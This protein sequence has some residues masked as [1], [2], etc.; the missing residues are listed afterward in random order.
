MRMQRVEIDVPVFEGYDFLRLGTVHECEAN[1]SNIKVCRV[2]QNDDGTYC[3]GLLNTSRFYNEETCL[4]YRKKQP[5]K[6]IY[7]EAREDYLKRGDLY[8]NDNG[9]VNEWIFKDQSRDK[10]I[11]LAKV[12]DDFEVKNGWRIQKND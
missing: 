11:I 2:S 12:H 3:Y 5:R 10:N 1:D 7:E 6:I 9:C 4:I 8:L